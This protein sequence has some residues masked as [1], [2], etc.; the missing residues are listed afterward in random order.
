MA[1]QNVA[2]GTDTFAVNPFPAPIEALVVAKSLAAGQYALE[3]SGSGDRISCTPYCGDAADFIVRLQVTPDPTGNG[4]VDNTVVSPLRGSYGNVFPTM[5]Q[6]SLTVARSDGAAPWYVSFDLL[7]NANVKVGAL[8]LGAGSNGSFFDL[9]SVRIVDMN[10]R[11]VAF[12]TDIF[13]TNP[14]P[15]SVEALAVADA[16][17]AG[18]YAI[19]VSGSGD[20]ISCT[21][22]CGDAADFIVRLQVTEAAVSPAV[23]EPSAYGLML[24]GLAIVCLVARRRHAHDSGARGEAL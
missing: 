8:G 7:A 12:G 22:Y 4:Q 2:F 19:E 11:N 18:H 21:P 23:P 3:V 6:Q 5:T 15:D 24:A 16:L 20:R 9:T 10:G 1:G 14:F 13:A 17:P